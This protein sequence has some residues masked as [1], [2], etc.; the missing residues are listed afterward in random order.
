MESRLEK[1]ANTLDTPNGKSQGR[2]KYRAGIP[3]K[4]HNIAL[5]DCLYF[6]LFVTHL[7]DICKVLLAR[8]QSRHRCG[9]SA[10]PA[11]PVFCPFGY[12]RGSWFLVLP[13]PVRGCVS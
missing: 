11:S 13:A 1:I 9:H 4:Q 12:F 10:R 6:S 8:A 5:S 7:I 3:Y 2:V